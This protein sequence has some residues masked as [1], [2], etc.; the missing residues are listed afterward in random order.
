MTRFFQEGN[1]QWRGIQD[2]PNNLFVC[3]F[4][5]IKVSSV[6]GYRLGHHGDGSGPQIGAIYVCPNCGGAS[7]FAPNKQQFPSPALGSPVQHVPPELN[8]LYEEARRC[9]SQNCYTAAVLL[10]RK[11]LMNIAVEQGAL[12]GLKF[13]EYVNFLS[14]KGYIPPNGKH[15]VDHIRKKGNEATHEIALMA[16]TDAKDLIGFIEMLLRF[17]YEFPK[18]IPVQP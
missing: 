17:L 8:T 7:F 10:C 15:W 16:E 13:I 4:C 12:E 14:D 5:N 3:G 6:K 9:T 1:A 11:M 18:M 2:L